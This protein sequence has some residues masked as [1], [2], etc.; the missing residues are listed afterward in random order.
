MYVLVDQNE[1]RT[2]NFMTAW[3]E[4]LYALSEGNKTGLHDSRM[5]IVI[6][7]ELPD[8]AEAKLSRYPFKQ[9]GGMATG[10]YAPSNWKVLSDAGLGIISAIAKNG[11]DVKRVQVNYGYQRKRKWRK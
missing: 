1:D 9:K 7:P 3:E 10:W 11:W 4:L 2:S 5:Q 6:D 8:M